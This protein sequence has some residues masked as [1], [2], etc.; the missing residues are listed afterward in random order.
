MDAKFSRAVAVQRELFDYGNLA[1]P[2]VKR[3]ESAVEKITKYQRRMAADI[4]AIGSELLAVKDKLEHGQF[5]QW[6]DHYFGWSQQ[7][8]SR[9]MQAATVFKSL[10]LSIFT[11]DTSALY[12][13][14]SSKCP[15]EVRDDFIERAERGEH[16]THATVKQELDGDKYE[17]SYDDR[18]DKVVARIRAM[19]NHEYRALLL[20]RLKIVCQELEEDE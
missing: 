11:I 6:I 13:L 20:A 15:D 14:S 16:I 5:G 18:I 8:G 3:C 4:V 2:E 7:T 1:A 12:L 17:P 10:N 19:A 9:M